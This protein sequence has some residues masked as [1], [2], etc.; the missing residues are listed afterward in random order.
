[1]SRYIFYLINILFCI[2][3]QAQDSLNFFINQNYIEK[4][5]K[6]S[7]LVRLESKE[8]KIRFFEN[9]MTLKDCNDK[10]KKEF[11]MQI[12][13]IKEERDKFNLQFIESFKKY[14]T[15]CPV[16]FYY[17]KDHQDL[18]N[19]KFRKDLFLNQNLQYTTITSI[20]MD[21]ILI[22]K[23]DLSPNSENEGWM[24]QTVEGITL[25]DGFPYVIEND[26]KTIFNW[27]SSKDHVKLN[28]DYM[29]RKLNK[30]L[31]TY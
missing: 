30:K 5:H 24:F 7:L 15:F 21:S 1:M 20:N 26:Y 23:K 8:K 12:Q 11:S 18:V 3:L 27:L 2:Q 6:G 17:D 29:V 13:S 9:E 14:F 25:K 22:L 19:S 4:L 28:C 10:C 16:Y 31:V